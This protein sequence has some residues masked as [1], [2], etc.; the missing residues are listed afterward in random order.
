MDLKRILETRN[1]TNAFANM[2]GLKIS[3]IKEGYARCDMD[4]TDKMKNP[5]DSVHGGVLFTIADVTGGAAAASHG[6]MITT[7]DSSF[8]YLRPGIGTKK[9]YSIA[10]EIKHGKNVSVYDVSVLDEKDVV[11]AEGIFTYM[12]LGQKLFEED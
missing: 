7:L 4:V 2:I 1:A 6:Y 9:L 8:H 3:D 10:K 11:L 5:I 12:S